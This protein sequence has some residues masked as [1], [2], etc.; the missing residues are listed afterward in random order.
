MTEAFL[1]FLTYARN[2]LFTRLVFAT[3]KRLSKEQQRF[4]RVEFGRASAA[5]L[6]S[7]YTVEDKQADMKDA[8]ARFL[9]VESYES[10]EALLSLSASKTV[11]MVHF[12]FTLQGELQEAMAGLPVLLVADAFVA[13]Q[14]Q[15]KGLGRHLFNLL[16]LVARREKMTG[17]MVGGY[18]ELEPSFAPFF[19]KL[20]GWVKDTTWEPEEEGFSVYSKTFAAASP[21]PS[22][23]AAAV[24][25]EAPAA[26]VENTPPAA[27]AAVTAQLAAAV[28]FWETV[29]VAPVA[30]AAVAAE[31]EEGVA[32]GTD[33]EDEEDASSEDEEETAARV[34]DELVEMFHEKNGRLPTE[35]EMGQWRETL[36]SA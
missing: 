11:A 8:A 5:L 27:V 2:G 21:A 36:R 24:K 1:P 28:P 26:D 25:A 22:A 13:P 4:G 18:S 20:K 23:P 15:R 35:E 34:M 16:E 31:P 3:G 7:G 29:K 6:S 14:A 32:E 12:R 10:E 19:L 17:V 33:E 30:P 9:F